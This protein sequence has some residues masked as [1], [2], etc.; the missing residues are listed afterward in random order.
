MMENKIREGLGKL[1]KTQATVLY[2]TLQGKSPEWIASTKLDKD[3]K[4]Y[5]YHM[6]E[7]YA[8]L[9]YTEKE[10]WTVK[11]E[12]LIREVYPI[13]SEQVKSEKDLENWHIIKYNYAKNIPRQ[14]QNIPEEPQ[15]FIQDE[16]A[17]KKAT[18]TSGQSQQGPKTQNKQPQ[19]AKSWTLIILGFLVGAVVSCLVI[20]G[21]ASIFFRNRSS[22]LPPAQGLSTTQVPA[23]VIAFNT[24]STFTPTYTQT[25]EQTPTPTETQT[26]TDTQIPLPTFTPVPTQVV[27]FFENFDRGLGQQISLL[28]GNVNIVNGELVS[29]EN[30]TIL[31]IGDNSWKN[32]SVEFMGR[33]DSCWGGSWGKNYIGLHAKDRNNMIAVL[34]QDCEVEWYLVKNGNWKTFVNSGDNNRANHG[35]MEKI[36]IDVYDGNYIINFDRGDVYSIYDTTY[37]AGGILFIL[38]KGTRLDNLKVVKLP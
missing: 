31:M 7:V 22:Q 11:R 2:W 21:I 19:P 24:T 18:A 4:T 12:R 23:P 16:P 37:N 36:I 5:D 15:I 17:P 32:Y 20:G 25:Q 1:S 13:F 10:H 27:L 28:S 35:L 8:S 9:G 30:N 3:R 29:A 26:P 6:S 38:E 34:W 14:E 33:P